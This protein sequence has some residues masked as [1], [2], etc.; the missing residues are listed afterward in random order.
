M[1][2]SFRKVLDFLLSVYSC[3][4]GRL[5]RQSLAGEGPT[6]QDLSLSIVFASI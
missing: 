2:D 1:I 6:S 4:L 3:F 5:T